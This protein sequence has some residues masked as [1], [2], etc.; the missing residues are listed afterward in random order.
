MSSSCSSSRAGP[1][2]TRLQRRASV[3]RVTRGPPQGPSRSKRSL[4]T[5]RAAREAEN[6]LHARRGYVDAGGVFTFSYLSNIQG[7]RRL[8]TTTAQRQRRHDEHSSPVPRRPQPQDW[9]RAIRECDFCVGWT[10]GMAGAKHREFVVSLEK[11]RTQRKRWRPHAPVLGCCLPSGR[12]ALESVGGFFAIATKGAHSKNAEVR[13][14]RWE[15]GT[16]LLSANKR[17][18]PHH[19]LG[20]IFSS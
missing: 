9:R 18:K 11:H 3:R 19:L 7:G 10:G 4:C 5:E 17:L 16:C 2:P 6:P 1:G 15:G 20:L 13:T 14:T 8:S 12:R